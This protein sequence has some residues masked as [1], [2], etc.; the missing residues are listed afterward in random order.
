MTATKVLVTGAGGFIGSHLV[1]MLVRDGAA[2]RAMI[3][4]TS[5]NQRGNL[6]FLP[7]DIQR[8][9][10]YY[11]GDLRD[12]EAVSRAL[13][14]IDTVYHLGAIIAI[15]YS[16][17]H[18][19]ETVA[20]NVTGTLN[21]LQGMRQRGTRCGI[22]VST[23]EVYGTAQ[24]VPINE[25]HPLQSQSPYAASKIGA[26]AL[27]VSFHRS[28]NTPVVVVR[29][30]NTFGPRQSARAVIPTIISQALTRDTIRLGAIHPY[31]DYTYATDTARGLIMA[32][33]ASAALGQ[34]VNL[35]TGRSETIGTIAQ[36]VIDLVERPV[37]VEAGDS[38]RMRPAASEVMRL[39][40]DNRLAQ[41]IMG[42]QPRVSLE[43]GL[44]HTIGW[45]AANLTLFDPSTFAV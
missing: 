11:A 31:R 32:A 29:P 1:D 21:V 2:V 25:S 15:P 42:W 23:S 38:Q 28:F 12:G 30:F 9:I 33:H 17:Q 43:D 7:S 19:E 8:E 39:E 13:D 37:T 18:P 10:E 6:T 26:E 41:Q 45:I 24:Y 14:G 20:V 27:A 5:G 22:I 16:Y 36:M 4:Y 44:R 40:S 35:G 34:V 3:R